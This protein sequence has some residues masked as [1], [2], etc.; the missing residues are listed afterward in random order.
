MLCS[1]RTTA[2]GIHMHERLTAPCFIEL[3]T[4]HDGRVRCPARIHINC[5]NTKGIEFTSC[6]FRASLIRSQQSNL[7]VGDRRIARGNRPPP[8]QTPSKIAKEQ[9]KNLHYFSPRADSALDEDENEKQKKKK[10][11][12]KTGSQLPRRK[13]GFAQPLAQ[14][15][16]VESMKQNASPFIRTGSQRSRIRVQDRRSFRRRPPGQLPDAPAIPTRK[17]QNHPMV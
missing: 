3:E 15:K 14:D 4:M 12:T 1:T 16:R 8:P 17:P 6:H 10:T 2:I 9:T 7:L 13:S 11:L 5:D